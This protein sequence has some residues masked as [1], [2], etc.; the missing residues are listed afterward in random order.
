MGSNRGC[1]NKMISIRYG[2]KYVIMNDTNLFIQLHSIY[3]SKYV[4]LGN[5]KLHQAEVNTN[6]VLLLFSVSIGYILF[7]F[8]T[9]SS[10][11][12]KCEMQVKH[13]QCSPYIKKTTLNSDIISAVYCWIL[14]IGCR[15]I[16]P[17]RF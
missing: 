8:S 17:F 5:K 11:C 3:K 13:A 12:A 2:N 7:P 15:S 6:L 14:S 10:K 4:Q 16:F 9:I 1:V